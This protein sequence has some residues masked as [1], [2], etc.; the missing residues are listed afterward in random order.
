MRKSCFFI[1][2]LAACIYSTHV[3]SADSTH[4]YV[5]SIYGHAFKDAYGK[6]IHTAYYDPDHDTRR[7]CGNVKEAASAPVAKKA[8]IETV[9]MSDAG[10]VLFN[11][12]AATLTSA[13]IADLTAFSKKLGAQSDITGVTIDGYTDAIG[14][15]E[16][17]L[18]LSTSRAVAVKQ[19]FIKNGIPSTIITTHGYGEKD[20][21]VS[22]DCIKKYGSDDTN[23]ILQLEAKLKDKKHK[24]RA[25]KIVK[26]TKQL[27][28]K[29]NS[30][31]SKRNDLIKCTAP[32]RRVVFTIEHNRQ[33]EE[34]TDNSVES[35]STEIASP[36]INSDQE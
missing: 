5:V 13:G 6:C 1:L 21:K 14:S 20:V 11:F 27:E 16:Y 23:L 28:Q 32:D 30:L 15:S 35:A 3:Y 25:G 2:Q 7:D 22:N 31:Q 26:E 4:G 9:T 24:S 17:N 12:N 10:D 36:P 19:V 8:A 18:K 33:I 34:S 29:L